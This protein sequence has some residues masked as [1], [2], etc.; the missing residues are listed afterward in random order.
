[1]TREISEQ[2]LLKVKQMPGYIEVSIDLSFLNLVSEYLMKPTSELIEEISQHEAAK[3]THIH[4]ERYG[5]TEEPLFVFWKNILER[6]STQSPLIMKRIRKSLDYINS[7]RLTMTESLVE[8]SEYLPDDLNLSCKLYGMIGYDIGIVSEGDAFLNLAHPHF[9]NEPRELT[10]FAM[11]EVHHVG[12]ISYNPSRSLSDIKTTNDL[13]WL[14]HYATHLEGMGVYTP[15]RRRLRDGCISH[16]DY[17][18][19]KN[20]E[21]TETR[22]KRYFDYLE[23]LK[24]EESRPLTD[25]DFDIIE[26]MS[27]KNQRLWY[28]A[29]AYMAEAIDTKSSR[30]ALTDTISKGHDYFFRL[31]SE[32]S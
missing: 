27:G 20:P 1:M 9:D 19:L 28:I 25:S 2:S 11:H 18:V 23:K 24:A 30:Q 8:V 4:A 5:N 21:E 7:N 14:V 3:K 32:L 22:L 10:Y 31:Y 15:L 16:E 26:E 6:D 29:G 12:Y 17:Q 13:L